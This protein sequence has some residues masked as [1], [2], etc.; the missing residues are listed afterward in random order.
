MFLAVEKGLVYRVEEGQLAKEERKK[1]AVRFVDSNLIIYL[2]LIRNIEKMT[3]EHLKS[4]QT[5]KEV[6]TLFTDIFTLSFRYGVE[7]KVS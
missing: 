5:E 1:L 4:T 2:V 3:S 6:E 7:K